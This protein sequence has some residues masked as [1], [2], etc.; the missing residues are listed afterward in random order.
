MVSNIPGLVEAV[1]AESIDELLTVVQLKDFVVNN[2]SP[3]LQGLP[4]LA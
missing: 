1:Q 3:L 4:F 2:G